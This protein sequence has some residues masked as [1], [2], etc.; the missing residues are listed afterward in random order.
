MLICSEA[1]ILLVY[2]QRTI[3]EV[4]DIKCLKKMRHGQN[5]F[6]LT[7]REDHQPV[8]LACSDY[9]DLYWQTDTQQFIFSSQQQKFLVINIMPQR[10]ASDTFLRL[11]DSVSAI[12]PA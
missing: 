5:G 3:I 12:F 10:L 11:E 9:G 1:K 6:D 8:V 7:L 2:P 4:P